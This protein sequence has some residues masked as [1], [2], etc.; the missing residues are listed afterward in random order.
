MI[1]TDSSPRVIMN[2]SKLMSIDFRKIKFKDSSC[3]IPQPLSAF[4]KIFDLKE[5]KKGL[6]YNL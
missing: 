2:G 4:S 5:L 3:F 6:F 1:P